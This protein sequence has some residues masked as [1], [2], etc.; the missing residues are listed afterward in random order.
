MPLAAVG[1]VTLLIYTV[2]TG[3][4]IAIGLAQIGEFSFIVSELGHKHHLLPDEAHN[5]IV[6]CAIV[7]IT[8]N[9]LLFRW[10]PQIENGL[11]S[12]PRLWSLLNDRSQRRIGELNAESARRVTSHE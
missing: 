7:S 11:R 2:H 10:L 8:I 9:P 4:T 1:I 6:A 5:L 3:L 12:V